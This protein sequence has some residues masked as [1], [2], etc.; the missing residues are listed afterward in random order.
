MLIL[1]LQRLF[2]SLMHAHTQKHMYANIQ[3]FKSEDFHKNKKT[4]RLAKACREPSN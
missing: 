3:C 1:S 2:I 4:G